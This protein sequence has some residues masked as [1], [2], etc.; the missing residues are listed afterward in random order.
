MSRHHTIKAVDFYAE[1][2]NLGADILQFRRELKF[3]KIKPDIFID[4]IYHGK[5]RLILLEIDIY[6]KTDSKKYLP[7]YESSFFPK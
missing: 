2:C 5:G 3:D 1:L 4:L 7:L 6:N